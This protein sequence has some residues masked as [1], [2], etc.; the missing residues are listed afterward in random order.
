M[1]D[2]P[3]DR[4]DHFLNAYTLTSA[5]RKDIR[6]RVYH[7]GHSPDDPFAIMI[8][9]DAIMEGRGAGVMAALEKLPH[10]LE[11]V[12]AA[13]TKKIADKVTVDINKRNAAMQAGLSKQMSALID[14]T[15]KRSTA[16]ADMRYLKRTAL[17]IMLICV[18]VG[19]LAAMFGY[20]L[21]KQEVHDLDSQY[22]HA[23]PRADASTWLGLIESN[24]NIDDI[25]WENCHNGGPQ[26]YLAQD[27][28]EACTVPLWMGSGRLQS[29]PPKP[30]Y[31][32]TLLS[33][34]PS[35]ISTWAQLCIALCIG[36]LLGGAPRECFMPLPC[37]HSAKSPET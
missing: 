24:P 27:N 20:A 16:K 18:I 10:Q 5:E 7:A 4:L 13:L 36:M 12:T 14:E 6:S 11:G 2:R 1:P 30:P 23:L 34:I 22:A 19:G 35:R 25:L 31:L 15:L 26:S 9:Q 37:S 8:A 32:T 28:R 17:H 29:A 21:G 3:H 33:L